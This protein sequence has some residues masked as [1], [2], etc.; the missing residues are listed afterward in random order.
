MIFFEGD[1]VTQYSVH[2]QLLLAE[3]LIPLL[4]TVFANNQDK[5]KLVTVLISVMSNVTPYLKNHTYVG[6]LRRSENIRPQILRNFLQFSLSQE[7]EQQQ[8]LRVLERAGD[9][10]VVHVR[11]KSVEK[12]SDGF[13]AGCESIPNGI[14]QLAV[15]E[16]DRGEPDVP[17]QYVDVS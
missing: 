17:G 1:A 9:H 12:G 15:L 14:H 13:A 7:E 8:F 3:V 6:R 10:F 16:N 5:E 4:D 2:A 11:E